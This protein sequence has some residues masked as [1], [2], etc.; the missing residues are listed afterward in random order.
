MNRTCAGALAAL[1]AG[2]SGAGGGA[3][4]SLDVQPRTATTTANGPT[5]AFTVTITGDEGTP[6]WTLSGPGDPGSVQ[7]TMGT[8]TVYTPPARVDGTIQ[9]TLTAQLNERRASATITV[10]PAPAAT[11]AGRVVDGLRLPIPGATVAIAGAGTA[12]TDSNGAFTLAGVRPPYDAL[13]RVSTEFVVYEGLRRLDPTLYVEPAGLMT[14]PFH[15]TVRGQISGGAGTL[16]EGYRT[17]VAFGSFDVLEP[18]HDDVPTVWAEADGLGAYAIAVPLGSAETTGTLYAVQFRTDAGGSPVEYTG[19]ATLGGVNLRNDTVAEGQHLALG[20]A[21]GTAH[22][23]GSAAFGRSPTVLRASARFGL[24]WLPILAVP[25][26]ASFDVATP[27]W[28]EEV[29]LG[30]AYGDDLVGG[31]YDLAWRSALRPDATGVAL[32][33]VAP[34]N[35]VLPQDGAVVSDPAT[36]FRWQLMDA[37][38]PVYVVAFD[39][40]SAR[41][42]VVTQ[43]PGAV[44]L[45]DLATAFGVP[46]PRDT[47]FRW[48]V[49]GATAFA[50]VDNAAGPGTYRLTNSACLWE[51]SGYLTFRTPP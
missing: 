42:A 17:L 29:R 47:L 41:L 26:T 45:P 23:L 34:P 14:P 4:A 3:S 24:A 1:I 48:N 5:I 38:L 2:C 22:L 43:A 15:A 27:A 46:L 8:A 30:L 10:D 18:R 36:E 16:A 11:V 13:V 35:P 9:V 49:S 6:L 32:A 12:T 51:R 7:P 21:S 31:W 44:V 20:A 37:P 50:S 28:A 25:A 19:F 39:G 40:G 33:F